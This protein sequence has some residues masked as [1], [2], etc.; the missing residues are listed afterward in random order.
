VP[1]GHHTSVAT[2]ACQECGGVHID[3]TPRR[4]P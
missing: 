4:N 3:T 1:A 2:T